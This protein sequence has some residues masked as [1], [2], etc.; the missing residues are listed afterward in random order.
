VSELRN[1]EVIFKWVKMLH[2]TWHQH[3]ELT[4]PKLTHKMLR[5][6]F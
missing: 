3:I 4:S 1:G 2:T 6:G 5:S